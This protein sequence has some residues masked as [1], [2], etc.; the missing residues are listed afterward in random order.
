[1]IQVRDVTGI[2]QHEFGVKISA[3]EIT[4]VEIRIDGQLIH[5]S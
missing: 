5:V 2:E 3:E 1:M 4:F